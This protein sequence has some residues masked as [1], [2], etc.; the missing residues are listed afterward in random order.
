VV[1]RADASGSYRS[2]PDR[3]EPEAPVVGGPGLGPGVVQPV[4]QAVLDGADD[5][6]AFGLVEAGEQRV[7]EDVEPVAQARLAVGGDEAGV[8]VVVVGVSRVRRVAGRSGR[9]LLGHTRWSGGDGK[10]VWV[11]WEPVTQSTVSAAGGLWTPG[12]GG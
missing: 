7:P 8:G 1:C 3:A 12:V 6:L 2:L 4:A 9:V 10:T 11:G 5:G